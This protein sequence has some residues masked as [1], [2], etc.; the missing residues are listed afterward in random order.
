MHTLIKVAEIAAALAAGFWG[1]WF[2]AVCLMYG[3]GGPEEIDDDPWRPYY[4]F[5]DPPRGISG[6]SHQRR[7]ARREFARAHKLGNG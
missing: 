3:I 6:N 2:V 5:P 4:A 7:L 1:L